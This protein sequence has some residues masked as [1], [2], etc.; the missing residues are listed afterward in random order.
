MPAPH[1]HVAITRGEH[2]IPAFDL[3]QKALLLRAQGENFLFPLPER[4]LPQGRV[5]LEP[6][7]PE[8][9]DQRLTSA[10]ITAGSQKPGE[11]PCAVDD[12]VKL[13]FRKDPVVFADDATARAGATP[14]RNAPARSHNNSNPTAYPRPNPARAV[15]P[16]SPRVR[17]RLREFRVPSRP[18]C[19][20]VATRTPRQ[21]PCTPPPARTGP[22]HAP[23]FS[24]IPPPQAPRCRNRRSRYGADARSPESIVTGAH[25]VEAHQKI[26]GSVHDDTGSQIFAPDAKQVG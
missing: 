8:Q 13:V 21:P 20:M 7:T 26:G 12:L 10:K 5:I 23:A 18:P 24:T 4:P 3:I 11:L 2:L 16:L 25:D 9:A 17:A 22:R 19:R 15:G 14:R 6:D 1:P